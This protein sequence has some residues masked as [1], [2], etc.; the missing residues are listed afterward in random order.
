MFENDVTG[1]KLV[2]D[3]ALNWHIYMSGANPCEAGMSVAHS[4]VTRG[5]IQQLSN[6]LSTTAGTTLTEYFAHA[7]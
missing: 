4:M 5:H 2:I 1:N 3:R 7:Q 6:K